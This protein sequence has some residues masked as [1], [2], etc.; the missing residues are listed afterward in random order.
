ML[1]HFLCPLLLLLCISSTESTP[2]PPIATTEGAL[3]PPQPCGVNSSLQILTVDS[4]WLTPEAVFDSSTGRLHVVYG[5][6]SKDAFYTSMMGD[7]TWTS[8]IKLN[9]AGLQVTTTMGERGP[10]L[11]MST[12][13]GHLVVVWADLWTGAGCRVYARS[14]FSTDNGVTWSSPLIFAPNL[15]GIDGLAVTAYHQTVV[16]TF[17]VNISSLPIQNASSATWLHYVISLNGGVSWGL[18]SIIKDVNDDEATAIACSMCMTSPHFDQS[19]GT[20]FIAYRSAENN[21]R[22]FRLVQAKDAQINS[23]ETINFGTQWRIPYCPM[24]GPELSINVATMETIAYM[25]G[26]ENNVFWIQRNTSSGNFTRP[27]GTPNRE[28]NERYAS[29]VTSRNGGDTLLAYNVGPMAVSGDAAVK[30]ACYAYGNETAQQAG[31]LGR[32][33]AGTKP[34]VLALSAQSL[35]IITTAV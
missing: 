23:F 15:F 13:A 12:S 4:S 25:T 20:L 6:T 31:E 9:T 3:S 14:V 16:A 5:T 19:T 35:L 24:N 27:R 2:P 21:I 26:D 33:F 7:G 22:D 18:P 34:S 28:P 1:Q 32:S 17:H 30:Y 11:A 29:A 10:K 8:S